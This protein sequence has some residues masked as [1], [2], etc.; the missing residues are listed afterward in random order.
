VGDGAGITN[1]LATNA[2]GISGSADDV[3]L[4]PAMAIISDMPRNEP[5]DLPSGPQSE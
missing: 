3:T 4:S 5:S 1:L 2:S